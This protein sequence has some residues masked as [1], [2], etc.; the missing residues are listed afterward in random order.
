MIRFVYPETGH[1]DNLK[2]AFSR[3][4]CPH[5]HIKSVV[6]SLTHVSLDFHYFQSSIK[7]EFNQVYQLIQAQIYH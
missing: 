6:T 5:V 4:I 2:S 7:A 3:T 1:S